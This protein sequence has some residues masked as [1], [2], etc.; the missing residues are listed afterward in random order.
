MAGRSVELPA[1][2]RVYTCPAQR[3]SAWLAALG[4]ESNQVVAITHASIV[5]AAIVNALNARRTH[6]GA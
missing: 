1:W 4:D 5:R 6:F 3:V 2:R